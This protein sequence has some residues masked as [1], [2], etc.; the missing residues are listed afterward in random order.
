MSRSRDSYTFAG[1]P[2]LV[3][4]GLV[5]AIHATVHPPTALTEGDARNKSGHDGGR[6]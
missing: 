6:N 5:P 3:M 4:A 1:C 2:L